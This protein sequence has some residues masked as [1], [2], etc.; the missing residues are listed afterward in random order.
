MHPAWA[1]NQPHRAEIA[2]LIVHR[3][4]RGQGL[5]E[6]LMSAV[7]QEASAA[8]FSLLTLD[9]KRGG[10][11]ERL[12]RRMGWIHAGTIPRFAIDCDGRTPHDAVIFYRDLS[13]HAGH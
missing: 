12:Y 10:A 8:G 11:A 13:A 1:P 4:A 2:K 9:A 3:H 5:G 7:E 6:R